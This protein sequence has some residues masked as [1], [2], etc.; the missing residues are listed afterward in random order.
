MI[1]RVVLFIAI[2]ICVTAIIGNNLKREDE[3]PLMSLVYGLIVSWALA[4]AVGVPLII[5]KKPLSLM[6]LIL[7]VLY[8]LLFA[9]GV[10]SLVKRKRCNKDKGQ[11][12][13]FKSSEMIYL[14]LFLGIV[15]FQLYKTIFYAYADGDDAFYVAAARVAEASDK[16]YLTD[17][18][19]GTPSEILYRYALAP[20]PMWEAVLAQASGIQTTLLAHLILPPVLIVVTYIV[21][22][23]IGKLLFGVESREKRFMFLTL[24]AVFELFSNV[25]TST[26][27]T[28]LL[29]RARQGKEALAC[30]I[31]PLLFYELFRLVKAEGDTTVKDF[32]V[33][34]STVLAASLSSLLGNILTSIMLAGAVLW[35][36]I[37][38]KRFKN[39]VI[40]S[41]P[42][43]ISIMTVL[44]YIKLR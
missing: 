11:I 20:F 21:Y 31:L 41:A 40:I 39:M 17:A 18:Y 30:I 7:V 34:L 3:S 4:F 15:A 28:F 23:E 16:M 33:L 24:T 1:L 9:I 14:G 5:M 37:R 2:F 42:V 43:L 32:F 22:N 25:S 27:G 36:I 13:P 26:S 38:K 12:T 44:L 19:L 10:F 6:R 8:A 29:T 35:M